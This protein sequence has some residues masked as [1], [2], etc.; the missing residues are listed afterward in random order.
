[1]AK[2]DESREKGEGRTRSL[3]V[4]KFWVLKRSVDV[5]GVDHLVQMP[6]KDIKELRAR[7]Q[8]IH[9]GT[10]G[11]TEFDPVTNSYRTRS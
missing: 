6:A 8:H 1:M 10:L 9:T 5:D 7:H 11:K 4:D 3:L 2:Q